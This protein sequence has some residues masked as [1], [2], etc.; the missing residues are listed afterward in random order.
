MTQN[1]ELLELLK[2]RGSIGVNSFEPFRNNHRQLPR[3][4]DDL[5]KEDYFIEHNRQTNTSMTYVLVGFPKAEVIKP[6]TEIIFYKD[7][8]G[9]EMSKEVPINQQQELL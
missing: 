2:E 1:D 4:I 7:E 8:Q 5:E 6:K 9:H 3:M